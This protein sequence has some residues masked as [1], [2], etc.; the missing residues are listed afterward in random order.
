MAYVK[1]K[2][3]RGVYV[4]FIAGPVVDVQLNVIEDQVDEITTVKKDNKRADH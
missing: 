4:F 3:Q 2:N 1:P